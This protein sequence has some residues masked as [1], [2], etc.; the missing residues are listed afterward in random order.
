VY[1]NVRP[2]EIT[3]TDPIKVS[4]KS[5]AIASAPY[6]ARKPCVANRQ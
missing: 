3:S 5:I 2:P 4:C 6:S 1:A